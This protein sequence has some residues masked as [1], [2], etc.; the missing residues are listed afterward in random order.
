MKEERENGETE[1]DQE[2]GGLMGRV[3]GERKHLHRLQGRTLTITIPL[4]FLE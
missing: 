1:R 2:I 4:S 3:E